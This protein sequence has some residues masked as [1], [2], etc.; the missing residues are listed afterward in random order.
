MSEEKLNIRQKIFATIEALVKSTKVKELNLNIPAKTQPIP[1]NIDTGVAELK[2]AVP[3]TLKKLE[4]SIET[5]TACIIEKTLRPKVLDAS[6]EALK[7]VV[8]EEEVS[9]INSAIVKELEY[10]IDTQV[11]D[12]FKAYDVN[13]KLS[14][15]ATIKSIEIGKYK[16]KIHALNTHIYPSIK[17]NLHYF[18]K[19]TAEKKATIL[20]Y[21]PEREQLEFWKRAVIRSKLE[22]RQLELV[23][24]FTGIP[25]GN[26]ENIKINISGMCLNYSF[27]STT[28]GG[29]GK[30]S[31]SMR[32]IGV[33]INLETEKSLM[34][35][36]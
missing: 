28:T 22:P 3:T 6:I 23:G 25:R 17:E 1:F 24:I 19:F 33:F 18:N 32:D 27:K 20:S 30:K 15:I 35:S 26:V 4:T 36:K 5:R 31:E 14:Y 21:L 16:P 34:V 10:S 29:L 13:K 7:A 11:T 9:S 2:Y 12:F 8:K